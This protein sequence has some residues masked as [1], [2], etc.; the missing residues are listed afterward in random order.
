MILKDIKKEYD[1]EIER[2]LNRINVNHI[3]CVAPY[4]KKNGK[5]WTEKECENWIKK[6]SYHKIPIN[7]IF[8]LNDHQNSIIRTQEEEY[9]AL[10]NSLEECVLF[11]ND[12]I[13]LL[14]KQG[15]SL[16]ELNDLIRT[17]LQL[18]DTKIDSMNYDT[19]LRKSYQNENDDIFYL[20][21]GQ[22]KIP[23]SKIYIDIG[24]YCMH[25][26][27][28]DF[29]YRKLLLYRLKN[30][31]VD[32]YSRYLILPSIGINPKIKYDCSPTDI[33]ELLYA[34]SNSGLITGSEKFK[35]ILMDMFGITSEF[36]DNASHCI[37]NRQKAKSVFVQELSDQLNALKPSKKRKKP[38]KNIE[39]SK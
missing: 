6:D 27:N 8:L 35:A 31:L 11:I 22:K 37:R 30:Y 12:K 38:Q 3:V 23:K 17:T 7:N 25:L 5:S 19:W 34:I 26:V 29:E 33:C 24:T 18:L 28:Y 32:I 39:I 36:Y 2:F 10:F 15:E 21:I 4:H 20:L 13:D 1:Q 16:Y 14:C 9:Q